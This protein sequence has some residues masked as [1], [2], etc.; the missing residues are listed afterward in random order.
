VADGRRLA[1]VV[2]L[3]DAGR[4]ANV[5]EQHEIREVRADPVLE[6]AVTDVSGQPA[7]LRVYTGTC[8]VEHGG[9]K[10]RVA[11]GQQ[12]TIRFFVPDAPPLPAGESE[13]AVWAQAHLC[14]ASPVEQSATGVS[15]I[16]A[17]HV[18]DPD[19]RPHRLLQAEMTV[20][21]RWA[22]LLGYHITVLSQAPGGRRR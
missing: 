11:G 1:G 3:P 18:P 12:G 22:L 14:L 5:A 2:R 8:E 4:V 9:R 19:G 20:Y 16:T 7:W 10:F 17:V 6:Y 21:G 15:R 13:P